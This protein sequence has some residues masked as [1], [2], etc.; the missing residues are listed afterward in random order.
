MNT[1]STSVKNSSDTTTTTDVINNDS[2]LSTVTIN[3]G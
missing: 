1:D 3:E 2:S